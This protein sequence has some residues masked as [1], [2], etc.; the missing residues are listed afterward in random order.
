MTRREFL[1]GLKTALGNE[2]QGPVIQ[3]NVKYYDGY[4]NDEVRKGRLEAE[5]IAELGDPWVI[6]RTIIGTSG[7]RQG[8]GYEEDYGYEPEQSAYGDRDRSG[9]D[10]VTGGIAW[11][12]KLLFL[13]AVCG[14][15][16]L[17]MAVIGGIV[18]VLAPVVIPVIIVVFILRLFQ[19][20][21]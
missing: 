11:W 21:R 19:S 15:L 16:L 17:V 1:D 3:E 10:R 8:D 7:G 5:V 20:R 14:I 2:M 12:K 18:S 13:L 4:I 6:A 9:R